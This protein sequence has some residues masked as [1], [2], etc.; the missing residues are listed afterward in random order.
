MQES[1]NKKKT[2]QTEENRVQDQTSTPSRRLDCRWNRVKSS[3]YFLAANDRFIVNERVNK[4]Q[5]RAS[6]AKEKM[7]PAVHSHGSS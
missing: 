7:S 6:G 2:K 1:K 5:I 3:V 4:I